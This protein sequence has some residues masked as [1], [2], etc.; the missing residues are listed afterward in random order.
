[1]E[2]CIEASSVC[3]FFCHKPN[4]ISK[5]LACYSL[6]DCIKIHGRKRQVTTG[7]TGA[8]DAKSHYA[9]QILVG[10]HHFSSLTT[11]LAHQTATANINVFF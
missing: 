4:P 3:P 5:P 1:M 11:A 9:T 6:N 2:A 10:I 7:A 8:A